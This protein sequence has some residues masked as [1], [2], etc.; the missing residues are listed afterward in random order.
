M[1]AYKQASPVQLH[2][3]ALYPPSPSSLTRFFVLVAAVLAGCAHKPGAE[4]SAARFRE[5]SRCEA[6]LARAEAQRGRLIQNGTNTCT[7]PVQQATDRVCSE[8][9]QL[10]AVSAALHDRDADTR[11]LRARETCAA[12]REHLH[13]RCP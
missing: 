7:P 2:L 12:A 1:H 11:C 10:C 5:L 13:A 4:E 3:A 6:E 9:H 8:G